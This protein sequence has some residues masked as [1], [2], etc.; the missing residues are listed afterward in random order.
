MKETNH[1]HANTEPAALLRAYAD[2]FTKVPPLGPVLDLACGGGRNG[3]YL[4]MLGLPV[5]LCDVS[6]EALSRARILA[7]EQGVSP[8]FMVLDLEKEGPFPLEEDTYGGI[9]VF[10]YL[11][12]PLIPVIR[13]AIRSTGILIY[14]TF[15]IDQ[16]R[17]GKPTNPDYLLK[18][19][20]LRQWFADW[21]ILH[22]SEG[23]QPALER[24]VAQIVCRKP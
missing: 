14:E 20:E 3:I 9:I 13:K 11:H 15:T 23:I 21:E 6:E 18:P 4:A 24:A 1:N 12:R 2:L 10:R 17:Y 7:R 19:G 8:Q 5:I 22:Y 16:V